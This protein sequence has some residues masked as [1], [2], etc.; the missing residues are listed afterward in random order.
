FDGTEG[1][2]AEPASITLSVFDNT[3][4]STGFE[5]YTRLNNPTW[6]TGSNARSGQLQEFIYSDEFGNDTVTITDLNHISSCIGASSQKIPCP[7]YSYWAQAPAL[8]GPGGT[9]TINNYLIVFAHRFEGEVLPYSWTGAANQPGTG[10]LP[11]I[12]AWPGH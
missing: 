6:G 10:T 11:N 4:G 3:P 12:I 8:L 2:E 1:S 7:D 5:Q 9:I